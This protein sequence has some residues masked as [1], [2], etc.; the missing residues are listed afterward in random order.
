MKTDDYFLDSGKYRIEKEHEIAQKV[1]DFIEPESG[2]L[3]IDGTKG[4]GEKIKGQIKAATVPDKI[5]S[6]E[7]KRGKK[8]NRSLLCI[9]N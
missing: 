9:S 4:V 3:K 6:L 7:F 8:Y 2:I 5:F 1:D